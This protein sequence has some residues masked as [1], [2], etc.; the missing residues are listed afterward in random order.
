MNRFL[1]FFVLSLF[2]NMAGKAQ[3]NYTQIE[4]I[5][6][7]PIYHATVELKSGKDLILTDPSLE[8]SLLTKVDKP[9]LVLITDIHPDHLDIETLSSLGLEKV[10]FVVPAAVFSKLPSAFQKHAKVLNNGDTTTLGDVHIEAV[11]MYNLPSAVTIFHPKGRG[12]GYI[13]TMGGKRIYISGD[14]QNIPEMEKF[15][16]LD[17]AFL[18]MN[19]PYTMDVEEAAKAALVLHP[20]VVIPYHYRGSK[21]FSNIKEFENKV[22]SS[23]PNID[24]ELLHFYGN[25]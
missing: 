12:N 15:A 17:I 9:S 18:C 23:D 5:G 2:F 14:T 19:L 6:I 16:P 24:I 21:G 3:E 1:T 22:E 20:K 7:K 8:D 25:K 4:G 13:L 10:P 11:P